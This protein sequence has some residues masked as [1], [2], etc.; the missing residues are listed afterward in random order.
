[1]G[2]D[3]Q[4]FP[5]PR[6]RVPGAGAIAVHQQVVGR[7]RRPAVRKPA[8][9]GAAVSIRPATL[10]A[11]SAA[12]AVG[13]VATG[14]LVAET[15]EAGAPPAFSRGGQ[16]FGRQAVV[17]ATPAPAATAST[18]PPRSATPNVG[19]TS[20]TAAPGPSPS[21]AGE[22][23]TRAIPAPPDIAPAAP[24]P[25]APDPAA[26]SPEQD[27]TA[28]PAPGE[29]LYAVDGWEATSAPGSR[30]RFPATAPLVVHGRQDG[31]DG[32]RVTLDI[33]YSDSHAERQ[34]VRHGPEGV[35]V[36][37]EGGKVDFF[38]GMVSQTSQARY[39]PPVL[40]VPATTDAGHRWSGRSEARDPGG[41]LVRSES[42]QGH[43][44]GTEV[45]EVAG[46]QVR[47]VV[48]RWETEF[49]GQER[50][51]RRQTIWY[52]PQHAL[53]VKLHD[54]LHGERFNFAY[55]MDATLTLRR[56]PPG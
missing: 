19:P 29:Y 37:F 28:A 46:Q 2:R 45:L 5:P 40:R 52:S 24:P 21:P 35:E 48:V 30:R 42:W 11:L 32:T 22:A 38:G 54:R 23:A 26:P 51:W 15:R 56:L 44:R 33:E 4:R 36:L 18:T 14:L 27:A 47:A 49:S 25:P 12:L 10:L 39:D 1:M 17:P 7:L 34:V 16:P 53:W 55:D 9:E 13:A 20:A 31:P 50:G 3:L 41:R 43:V 8:P 6:L